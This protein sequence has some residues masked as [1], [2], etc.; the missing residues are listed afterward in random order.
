M[1]HRLVIALAAMTAST[2]IV[3]AALPDPVK[4]DAGLIVPAMNSPQDVRVFRGIP[5]GAP[6]VGALRWKPTQPPAKWDGVRSGDKF[7]PVCIQPKG[8]G[9]LNVSVDL[10]DSPPTSEDRSEERR[11]GKECRSR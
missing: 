6:P 10:P 9:R 2:A 7:G 11:V 8:V 1:P 5:F 3:S 4:T